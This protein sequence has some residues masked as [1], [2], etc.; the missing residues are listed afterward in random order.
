MPTYRSPTT[1][2]AR[3]RLL[4]E[5]AEWTRL[6]NARLAGDLVDAKTAQDQWLSCMFRLRSALLAIPT[7]VQQLA[8]HLSA[9]DI[10]VLDQE[11]RSALEL[12]A[13]DHE[14]D[15]TSAECLPGADDA[16]L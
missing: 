9:A 8:P 12:L 10:A 15:G 6:K 14:T 3:N 7:R 5:Q 13:D 11:I 4:K 16:D 2:R 1:V